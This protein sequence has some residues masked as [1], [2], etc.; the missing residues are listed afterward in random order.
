MHTNKIKLH[1]LRLYHFDVDDPAGRLQVLH[2]VWR[3]GTWDQAMLA[4]RAGRQ[5]GLGGIQGRIS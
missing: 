5:D 1:C 3:L 4:E 2:T